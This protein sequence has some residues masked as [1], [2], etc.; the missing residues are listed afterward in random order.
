MIRWIADCENKKKGAAMDEKTYYLVYEERY[1]LVYEAG[2]ERWGHGEDDVGLWA[3][4]TEWV[5]RCNL[6]GKLEQ[7]MHISR[8]R[9]EGAQRTQ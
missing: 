6:R 1:K 8:R 5:D 4:L 2:V 9:T 7:S 3:S